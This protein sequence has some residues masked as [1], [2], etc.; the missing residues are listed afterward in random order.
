MSTTVLV[1]IEV[2]T[3]ASCGVPFGISEQ[4]RSNLR[5]TKATF[6]CPSGHGQNYVGKTEAD[7]LR[8]QLVATENSLKLAREGRDS[9][10]RRESAAKGQITKLK[11]RA[12]AGTCIHCNRTFQNVARHMATKHAEEV[13]HAE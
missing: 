6:Y 5:R 11:K 13:T 4:Q 1:N 8:E 10:E 9:A 2:E 3:C 7:K 12:H